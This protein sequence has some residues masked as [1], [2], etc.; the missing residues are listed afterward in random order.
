ME[1]LLE[2]IKDRVGEKSSPIKTIKGVAEAIGMSESGFYV[3][4]KRKTTKY[5]TILSIAKSLE[6]D[7]NY[8]TDTANNSSTTAKKVQESVPD[9]D[10]FESTLQ[11]MKETFEEQ[12]RAKDRQIDSLTRML[13]SVL[14]K[15]EGV[16]S[17][18]LSSNSEFEQLMREY[19]GLV[20]NQPEIAPLLFSNPFDVKLVAPRSFN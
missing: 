2:K 4:L 6:V 9:F 13:E 7:A 19:R 8:F 18:P 11:L 14:G 16:I 3:M 10:R 5:G 12:L 17:L 20:L 15:S 1:H